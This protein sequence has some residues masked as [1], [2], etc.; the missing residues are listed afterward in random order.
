MTQ[1][2]QERPRRHCRYWQQRQ[3]VVRPRRQRLPSYKPAQL[4]LITAKENDGSESRQSAYSVARAFCIFIDDEP[5]FFRP[6]KSCHTVTLCALHLFRAFNGQT[7]MSSLFGAVGRLL[8]GSGGKAAAAKP[9][10]ENRYPLLR[11]LSSVEPSCEIPDVFSLGHAQL[12]SAASSGSTAGAAAADSWKSGEV[13]VGRDK[14]A[15]L[16]LDSTRMPK[17]VSR[18]HA[19]LT[20]VVADAAAKKRMTTAANTPASGAW[21]SVDPRDGGHVWRIGDNKSTNGIYVNGKK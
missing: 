21:S 10:A 17:M 1:S 7:A 14:L 11:S 5:I 15:H 9:S 20:R 19:K 2:A 12:A 18:F 4:A 3:Q 6:W 8:S 16:I 13:V